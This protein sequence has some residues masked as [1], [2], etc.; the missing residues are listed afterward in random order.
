MVPEGRDLS[1]MDFITLCPADVDIVVFRSSAAM[2]EV[3]E[4]LGQHR[5][6][7]G[8]DPLNPLLAQVILERESSMCGIRNG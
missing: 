5:C 1:A 2:H 8:S 3:R 6:Q 4:T 7:P